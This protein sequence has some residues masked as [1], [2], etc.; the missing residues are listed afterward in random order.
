MTDVIKIEPDDQE[1]KMPIPFPI[2]GPTP[3]GGKKT[4]RERLRE[5]EA[6]NMAAI[7]YILALEETCKVVL[8]YSAECYEK[9]SII[10]VPGMEFALKALEQICIRVAPICQDVED[11]EL[12]P[13]VVAELLKHG[14]GMMQ[15]RTIQKE[16]EDAGE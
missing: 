11:M 8:D 9:L 4:V 1:K 12:P 13:T 15:V 14:G 3:T 10:V 7:Q 6:R 16:T 5:S 2:G